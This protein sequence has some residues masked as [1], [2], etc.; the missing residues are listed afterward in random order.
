[1]TTATAQAPALHSWTRADYDKMI[2]SGLFVP[3]THIELLDGEIVDMTPQST[4]HATAIQLVDEAVRQAFG[5]GH[6]FRVQM[7]VALDGH[8]EPEPDVAVVPGSLRDY[9]RKHPETAV[10]VVEVADSSIDYDRE[11]KGR[12]YARASIGEYW[13]VNLGDECLEVYREPAG[14]SYQDE[15][16]LHRGDTVSPRSSPD[17]SIA[18]ADLLP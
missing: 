15:A 17:A 14:E 1:M 16:I 12:A 18:V 4:E 5:R 6:L 2:A 7:P 11:R 13:I 10:L 9:T 3:G 8:S